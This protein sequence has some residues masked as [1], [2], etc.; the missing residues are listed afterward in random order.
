MTVLR[1]KSTANRRTDTPPLMW[2][3]EDRTRMFHPKESGSPPTGLPTR[4]DTIRKSSTTFPGSE[5][6]S[7]FDD[8]FFKLILEFYRIILTTFCTV[9]HLENFNK[10]TINW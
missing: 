6:K 2:T 10:Y 7:H 9:I 8:I 4:R 5:S 3:L 1:C